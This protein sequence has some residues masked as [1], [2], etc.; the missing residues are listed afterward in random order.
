MCTKTPIYIFSQLKKKVTMRLK[1]NV[2]IDDKQIVF[3]LWL[4]GNH[5]K[6]CELAKM[7]HPKI[8]LIDV[9]TNVSQKT[10]QKRVQLVTGTTSDI[11]D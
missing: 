9:S 2:S 10:I 6:F 11:T 4:H 3:S 1:S 5:L 7:S 8:H